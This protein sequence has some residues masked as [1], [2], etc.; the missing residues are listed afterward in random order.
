L[1]DD[2]ECVTDPKPNECDSCKFYRAGPFG[3][4]ANGDTFNYLEFSELCCHYF[5]RALELGGTELP[6]PRISTLLIYVEKD[7]YTSIEIIGF[8]DTNNVTLNDY[9][10]TDFTDSQ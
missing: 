6:V 9:D 10:R 3:G 8:D 5:I 4:S 7:S 2:E 1:F